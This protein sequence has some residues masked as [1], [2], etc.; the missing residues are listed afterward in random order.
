MRRFT[1][2]MAPSA[3][4]RIHKRKISAND[5]TA[6]AI[7]TTHHFRTQNL[8]SNP[9]EISGPRQRCLRQARHSSSLWTTNNLTNTVVRL[10]AL[11]RCLVAFCSAVPSVCTSYQLSELGCF[12][13]VLSV[14]RLAVCAGRI[15]QTFYRQQSI[16]SDFHRAAICTAH[17]TSLL[18]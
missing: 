12:Q 6:G 15:W 1:T 10:Q 7:P 2:S 17:Q 9:L 16:S 5:A 11:P 4:S 8:G 18:C 3:L 14:L 13:T